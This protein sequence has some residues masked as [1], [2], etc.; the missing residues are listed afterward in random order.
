MLEIERK[1]IV[2]TQKWSPKTA[3]T[4][5]IQGY[6]SVDKE[7]I[8]RIRVK[9]DQAY[10]TIKGNQ[11]GI[12]RSEFEYEIPVNDA[13]ELL[14]LCHDFPINKT[15]YLEQIG[16][17]TWEID[18]FHD[19]NEGLVMA[20]VELDDEKQHVSLPDWIEKEVSTDH[21]YFN[22]WLSQHPFKKW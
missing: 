9:G 10:L 8:V 4:P 16:G 17:L 11:Q 3:G 2:D 15:R 20:E 13:R 21:R 12:T 18:V 6:L 7:R 19:D 5:I 22:S 1:F 14:P